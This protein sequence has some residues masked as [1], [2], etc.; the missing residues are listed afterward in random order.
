MTYENEIA[1]G[2]KYLDDYYRSKSWVLQI[3]LGEL[4][5]KSGCNCV[6]GQLKG[7]YDTMMDELALVEQEACEMGFAADTYI[8]DENYDRAKSDKMWTTLTEEWRVAIKD[9][10]DLGI[11]L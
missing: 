10:L 3:D 6:L 9:R 8:W 7:D 4:D 2:M 5:L 1:A 11:E